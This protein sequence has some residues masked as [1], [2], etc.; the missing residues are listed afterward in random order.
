[1]TQI[2]NIET[3]SVPSVGKLALAS[4]PGTFKPS[5]VT[6]SH[7]PGRKAEDGG[8]TETATPAVAVLNIHLMPGMSLISLNK[9]KGEDVTVRMSDGTVHLMSRAWAADVSE[10]GDGESK[11]TLTSNASEVM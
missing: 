3:V 8:Y 5:G 10:V 6:R 9:I 11:L 2:T 1:M 4:N 7:K